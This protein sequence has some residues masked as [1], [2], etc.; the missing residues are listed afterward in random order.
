M[1]FR[2]N[3]R[4]DVRPSQI[5][6]NASEADKILANQ[7]KQDTE[8]FVPALEGMLTTKTRVVKNTVVYPGP[9]ARYLYHGKLMVDAT[10][11]KGPANIPGVGPRFKK[12]SKLRA[13]DKN[14]I[15]QKSV[16]PDAQSEWFEASKAVNLDKW[17][18][19]YARAV[20]RG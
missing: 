11:G 13:T 8:R 12:G 1:S 2:V 4:V 7:V 9:Y 14:L 18:R 20:T 10:T 3:V 5:E 19:V 6:R 16:H 15:F 17:K